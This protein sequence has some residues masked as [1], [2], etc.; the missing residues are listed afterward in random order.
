MVRVSF[1]VRLALA[2]SCCAMAA[3]FLRTFWL[4][5]PNDT[6]TNSTQMDALD[7]ALQNH[8]LDIIFK[9]H[10]NGPPASYNLELM[11]VSFPQY[12]F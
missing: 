8:Y 3:A 12:G 4:P 6:S 7:A 1:A 11:Q 2:A 5:K 9:D 10:H